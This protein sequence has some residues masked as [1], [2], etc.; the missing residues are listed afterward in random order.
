[1]HMRP[2]PL[3]F[4]PRRDDESNTANLGI[5]IVSIHTVTQEVLLG[6]ICMLRISDLDLRRRIYMVSLR[7]LPLSPAAQGFRRFLFERRAREEARNAR[8][9]VT[10][11]SRRA[12][13][14]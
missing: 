9:A 4:A 1:M 14:R 12:R 5:S 7:D 13:S 2:C 6:R 11:R 8:P 3:F 10:D